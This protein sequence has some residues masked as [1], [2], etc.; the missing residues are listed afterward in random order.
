MNAVRGGGRELE[1]AHM[2]M[3][4]QKL[5]ERAAELLA[6]DGLQVSVGAVEPSQAEE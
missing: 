3:I 5:A 2:E 1:A 6:D 4:S